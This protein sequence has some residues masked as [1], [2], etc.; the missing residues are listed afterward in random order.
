MSSATLCVHPSSPQIYLSPSRFPYLATIFVGDEGWTQSVAAQ[1]CSTYS[2]GC[3][4]FWTVDVS[5]LPTMGLSDGYCRLVWVSA[6]KLFT[7]TFVVTCFCGD[8][9]S[10]Y[11]PGVGGDKKKATTLVV[12]LNGGRGA[13]GYCL[14]YPT[15]H[16]WSSPI[17][18]T[19]L[20]VA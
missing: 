4:F 10:R 9:N 13:I 18:V 6:P 17:H 8:A 2:E 19:A 11:M 14:C 1:K 3:I 5:K 16:N 20:T 7:T 15:Y 12:A